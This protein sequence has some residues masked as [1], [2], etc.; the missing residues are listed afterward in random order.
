MQK[1]CVSLSLL[2]LLAA[3]ALADAVWTPVGPFAGKTV[4]AVA[5]DGPF[6]GGTF[7]YAA[8]DGEGVF[9]SSDVGATW[10]PTPPGLTNTHVSALAFHVVGPPS[11]TGC[12]P[13]C[14]GPATV[15][16]ATH[17][18]GVFVL[19]PLAGAWTADNAGLTNFDVTA[20]A[21]DS[22][23][24]WAGTASGAVFRNIFAFSGPQTWTRTGAPADGT[25]V[26]AIAVAS[27]GATAYIGKANGVSRS[28]DGGATWTL[29]QQSDSLRLGDVRAIALDQTHPGTLYGAGLV[30]CA[31]PCTTP[32]RPGIMRSADGGDTWTDASG[33][34]AYEADA[35]IA[36]GLGELFAGTTSGVWRSADFGASWHDAGLDGVE[37]DALAE[38]PF[39]FSEA[40]PLAAGTVGAGLFRADLPFG[41]FCRS[42]ATSLC[43]GGGR[44]RVAVAWTAS[45]IGQS[46]SG[47]TVPLTADT[48]AFWFFQPSNLELVVKVLDGRTING[49]F[50]VFW[51]ALT[52]VGWTLTVTDT[53]TGDVRTYTN[54][55]GQQAS[56]SDTEAF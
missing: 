15:Y 10:T 6:D 14:R 28:R 55:E 23:G 42:D 40:I 48:G 54:P 33:N 53:T 29:L 22:T 47:R 18:G 52:N 30:G 4:T 16:A 24:V 41:D 49:K 31:P 17:G 5:N 32:V 3:P 12:P 20:L 51:G 46:G 25:P 44:F 26:R 13:P 34:L 2:S 45:N 37:V 39:P 35:L 19:R 27:D 21:A 50:W 56:G 38:T 7:L 36:S 11:P 43:V 9:R 8:V 1:L